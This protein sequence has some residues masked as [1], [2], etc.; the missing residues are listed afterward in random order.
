MSGPG[1]LLF[2]GTSPGKCPKPRGAQRA[3]RL[4]G[5]TGWSRRIEAGSQLTLKT[6]QSNSPS[7]ARPG[8]IQ[9]WK[10]KASSWQGVDRRDRDDE[11]PPGTQAPHH[12]RR[13]TDLG[14]EPG[15]SHI[16][17]PALP[18]VGWCRRKTGGL[19]QRWTF[20]P[21]GTGSGDGQDS[22]RVTSGARVRQESTLL[23]PGR[24]GSWSRLI[25]E[26]LV[27][28][29]EVAEQRRRMESDALR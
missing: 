17:W 14:H 24:P 4:A 23:P 15:P 27:A 16:E 18:G 11:P 20:P 1:V 19:D 12:V 22:L 21:S 3:R 25:G 13:D 6:A 2:A 26:R 28:P 9:R 8:T 10:N 29:L 7:M 5:R